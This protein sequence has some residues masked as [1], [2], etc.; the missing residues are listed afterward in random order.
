LEPQ[1]RATA[2]RWTVSFR[3]KVPFTGLFLKPLVRFVITTLMRKAS[4]ESA[5]RAKRASS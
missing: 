1:G 4:A 5:R 3:G 2:V